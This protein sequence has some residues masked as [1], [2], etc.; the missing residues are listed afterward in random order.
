MWLGLEKRMLIMFVHRGLSPKLDRKNSSRPEVNSGFLLRS[1]FRFRFGGLGRF[2]R[3]LR[4]SVLAD[5]SPS[6]KLVSHNA[7]RNNAQVGSI[8]RLRKYIC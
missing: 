6:G 1:L 5:G 2:R 7:S 8:L 3:C 4:V